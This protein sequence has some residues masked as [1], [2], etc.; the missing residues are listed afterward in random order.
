MT[1]P[2]SFVLTAGALHEAKFAL[3]GL[4]RMRENLA[5]SERLIVGGGDWPPHT[6]RRR[7][8]SSTR[9]GE[10][11]ER[12]GTLAA[13]LARHPDVTR[14]LNRAAIE[15][16]TDP[17]NYLGSAPQMV[18][19]VLACSADRGVSIASKTV[20]SAEGTRL[21]G[22]AGGARPPRRFPFS[23][24]LAAFAVVARIRTV[25][26]DKGYDAEHHRELCR[27]CGAVPQFHRRGLPRGSGLGQR[28]PA[29]RPRAY[30]WCSTA[31]RE[32]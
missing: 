12:G 20:N 9:P 26:A 25:F 15:R 1:I 8:T 27:S 10:L 32:F 22:P 7:T 14:H 3:G 17:A 24:L 4:M 16:L 31:A 19:R 29:L 30:S 13:A 6:A 5:I 18:D 21:I 11:N 28:C 23:S 2:E